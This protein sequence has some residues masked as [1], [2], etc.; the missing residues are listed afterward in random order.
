MQQRPKRSIAVI[1]H[2]ANA[3][4]NTQHMSN[5]ALSAIWTTSFEVTM[6]FVDL[7]DDA[8]LGVPLFWKSPCPSMDYNL[9]TEGDVVTDITGPR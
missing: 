9:T 1:L 7:A 6:E 2:R 4:E 8:V 5:Y 3:S